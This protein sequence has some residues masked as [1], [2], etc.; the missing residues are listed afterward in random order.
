MGGGRSTLCLHMRS[1]HC[2]SWALLFARL[3][4][5]ML[6]SMHACVLSQDAPMPPDNMNQEAINN[7]NGSDAAVSCMHAHRAGG[8][9]EGARGLERP[10]LLFAVL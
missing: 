8:R 3:L 6:S 2:V 10:T 5:C 9:H 7:N 4:T 1:R